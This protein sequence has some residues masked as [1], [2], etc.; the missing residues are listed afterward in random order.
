LT[1]SLKIWKIVIIYMVIIEML[2]LHH[3]ILS[4]WI[5]FWYFR[6]CKTFNLKA[7]SSL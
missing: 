6:S 7:S 5:N 1:N 3:Y 4:L 2:F